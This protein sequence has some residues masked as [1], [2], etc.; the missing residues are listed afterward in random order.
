[1][2]LV[3]Y[4]YQVCERLGDDDS[5]GVTSR[6]RLGLASP[7]LAFVQVTETHI[8]ESHRHSSTTEA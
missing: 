1:V 3:R 7:S 4:F 2:G 5:L 6:S 8:P